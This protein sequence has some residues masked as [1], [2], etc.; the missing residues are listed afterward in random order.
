MSEI[1]PQPLTGLRIVF[2]GMGGVF[3]RL[4]L[5]ALLRAG[6]GLRAVVEPADDEDTGGEPIARLE[7]SPWM[8]NGAARRGL[9]MVGGRTG[10]SLREIAAGARAPIYQVARP[11]D[12]RTLDTLAALQP[13]ALCVACFTRR[14]PP[15]LLALPRLGALNA[16]PSLLPENRGPDPI[17][18]T[19]HS[20]ARETGVT[21]HLMDTTLDTGPILA[22]RGEQMNAGENELALEA[23]LA[24]LAGSL[25]IE[26][27]AGRRAGT[28]IPIPQEQS[29]ATY[30]SWPQ[31]RDY[32]ITADWDARRAWVFACGVFGRLPSLTLTARDGARFQMIEPCGYTPGA[33][34]GSPWRLDG[35][36]LE[37]AMA[38]GIFICQALALD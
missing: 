35:E 4:P 27:L 34:L 33:T 13:D 10:R 25:F 9:M 3:S 32:A 22:Q 17:F 6:V 31:A 19:F 2:F 15:A 11:G 20:G 38:D 37:V 16:H 30:H 26:A 12:A 8:A 7:P 28:L 23:R 24:A 5:E 21:I 14:L 29:R 18:W 36:R 1:A